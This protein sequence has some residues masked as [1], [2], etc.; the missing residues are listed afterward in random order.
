[1]SVVGGIPEGNYAV[2][3][4]SGRHAGA[5]IT[6]AP[7]SY[8]LGAGADSDI[9]LTDEGMVSR[10]VEIRLDTSFC[11]I[12]S[13]DG[14]VRVYDRLINPGGKVVVELPSEFI[15][16]S[17]KV[18]LSR[19]PVVRARRKRWR[20]QF[21]VGFAGMAVIGGGVVLSGTLP[22]F[23]TPMLAG[24]SP[25]DA[26]HASGGAIAVSTPISGAVIPA[27]VS[28]RDGTR[29]VAAGDG[30]AAAAASLAMR[31]STAG[32]GERVVVR[33]NGDIVEATGAIPPEYSG[34]WTS[35]QIWFD[36]TFKG[37]FLLLHKV[38]VEA[39]TAAPKLAIQAIWAGA[40][41]YVIGADGD[42]Y[43]EGATLPGGWR[44]ET[45]AAHQVIVSRR[46]ERVSLNP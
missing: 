36:E 25:S 37:R 27:S 38:K 32:M 12:W 7:G 4:C 2:R 45:I 44:I 16:G 22:A 14:G 6:L 28:S 29:P 8:V 11:R 46:G 13:L 42:K 40:G 9:V 20:A 1:M 3:I 5:E 31:L 39:N 34:E 19:P 41:S 24:G 10:H 30:A 18:T 17:V 23:G 26:G 43:G 15:C 35:A 21:L 33:A